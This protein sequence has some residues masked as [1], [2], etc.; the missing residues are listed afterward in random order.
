MASPTKL[1]SPKDLAAARKDLESDP[2]GNAV[3]LNRGF[4]A[5]SHSDVYADGVPSKAVLVVG[6]PRWAGGASAMA[7]QASDPLA[8][9]ALAGA[10]PAG[11]ANIHVTEEWLLPL[12]EAR[13]AEL[14]PH[15]AWLF[16]LDT[17]DFVD[18]Q[19]HDVKP[20]DAKWAPFIAKLWEPEHPLEGYIRS[21]I[22]AGP[23]YGIY[24]GDD[25]VA[26]AMTHFETDRVSMMGFLH[27]KEGYRGR[28]YAKSVGCA[29][30]KDILK[31]GKIPALHVYVDNV[32]S[33]ELTPQMGFHR[34]KRQAWAFGVFR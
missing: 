14:D 30:I 3:V 9:K 26:W 2:V 22:E 16:A 17:R 28:G 20:V 11:P 29:L 13:A 4:D 8:A 34:V 33:L 24:D 27:V 23:A 1:D 21:R 31:R 5:E 15:A 25:L 18:L 6:A 19:E 32:P 12:V 7:F 10:I